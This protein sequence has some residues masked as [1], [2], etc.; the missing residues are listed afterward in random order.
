LS[1]LTAPIMQIVGVSGTEWIIIIII[2]LVLIF[3]SKKLPELARNV[4]KMTTEYEKARI[5]IRR[6]LEMA[7]SQEINTSPNPEREKLEDIAN[8]LGIDYSNKRDDEL[9]RTINLKLQGSKNK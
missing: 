2:F 9:R 5:Q 4:G 3:G 6:E 8:I 7:K 1:P